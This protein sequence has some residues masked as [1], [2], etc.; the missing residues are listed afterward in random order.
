MTPV[1]PPSG[2]QFEISLGDQRATIVE[3]GGGIRAYSVAGRPVLE[4]YAPTAMCD[5]GHG[6]VLI[7]WPGRLGDGRYRFDGVEHQL[8]ISEPASRTAIH[9][10]LRWRAWRALE[11]APERVVMGIRLHPLSG[12]PF[13]L[14]VRVEYALDRDGLTVTSTASNAGEVACPYGCGQHPYLSPAAGTIDDCR[15]ELPAAT[16]ILDCSRQLPRGREPVAG[17]P[18][19]FRSARVIGAAKLDTGFTDLDRD[20]TGRTVV[21]LEASDGSRSELWVEEGYGFVQIY[22]GDGLA[23]GRRRRG[24]AVEP[25]S[26]PAN[27]F[28]SGD[29]LVRLEPGGS[30]SARWGARLA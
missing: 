2:E 12:Y 1:S 28:Q 7:P 14:D 20:A 29:G 11:R 15:L 13:R 10:L 30:F 19:D 6:A 8:A 4:P 23:P 24:L 22:S 3:V 25:M 18:F 21:R 9:G 27:A 16:R 5:G 17:G 26:C